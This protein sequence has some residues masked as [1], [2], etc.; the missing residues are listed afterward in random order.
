[1]AGPDESSAATIMGR[2]ES[3]TQNRSSPDGAS[4][5]WERKRRAGRMGVIPDIGVTSSDETGGGLL[6]DGRN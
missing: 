3:K 5:F 4:F 6:V 1:M 2:G